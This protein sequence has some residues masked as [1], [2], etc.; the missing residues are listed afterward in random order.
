MSILPSDSGNSIGASEL[1]SIALPG[2]DV[3]FTAGGADAAAAVFA[4]TEREQFFLQ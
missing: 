3:A 2:L 4:V 1:Q